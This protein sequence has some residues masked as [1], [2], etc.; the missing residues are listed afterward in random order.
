MAG[1]HLV[2]ISNFNLPRKSAMGIDERL[3]TWLSCF[4][5]T[6]VNDELTHLHT[7]RSESGLDLIIELEK[8]RR[9]SSVSVI[10]VCYSDHRLVKATLD[11]ARSTAPRTTYNYQDFRRM[12]TAAFAAYIRK[13]DSLT[14]PS[15]D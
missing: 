8:C 14:R 7:N 13:T 9:V 5:L 2:L 3:S 12:D 15:L 11:C 10:P 6:A 1:G 4:N